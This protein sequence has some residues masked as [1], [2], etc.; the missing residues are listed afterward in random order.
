MAALIVTEQAVLPTPAADPLWGS[1]AAQGSPGD[2]GLRGLP[3][4]RT[5]GP[6][7]SLEMMELVARG[8]LG[9]LAL[10]EKLAAEAQQG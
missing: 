6:H 1:P 7:C 4:V 9:P 8:F 10:R 3:R 5:G 2:G